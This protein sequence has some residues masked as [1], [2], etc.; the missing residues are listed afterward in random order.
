VTRVGRRPRSRLRSLQV[1]HLKPPSERACSV[2]FFRS[3][4]SARVDLVRSGKLSLR[5]AAGLGAG[6]HFERGGASYLI[7]WPRVRGPPLVF[8]ERNMHPI[9]GGEDGDWSKEHGP[10][11]NPE[12]DSQGGED[13]TDI[14]WMRVS[15]KDP[16]VTS[17]R[18]AGEVGLISVPSRRNSIAAVTDKPI[19]RTMRTT[20]SQYARLLHRAKAG[21]D[22]ARLCASCQT[23]AV[24]ALP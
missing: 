6:L 16:E 22:A 19:P 2:I 18:F 21:Q 4:R 11:A 20:P 9:C 23:Q 3:G 17:L 15:R 7:G 10:C 12:S 14:H 8:R 1:V 13:E 5:Q 24:L